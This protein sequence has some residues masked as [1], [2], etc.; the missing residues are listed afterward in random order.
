MSIEARNQVAQSITHIAS[1][2]STMLKYGGTGD[3]LYNN[4]NLTG[5]G[6]YKPGREPMIGIKQDDCFARVNF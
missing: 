5:G 6:I 1:S 2:I 4:D 3:P